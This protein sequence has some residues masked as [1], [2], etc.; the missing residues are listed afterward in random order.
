MGVNF[1]K[2]KPIPMSNPRL[3]AKTILIALVTAIAV[4]A[5]AGFVAAKFKLPV[6]VMV[7]L[8]SSITAFAFFKYFTKKEEQK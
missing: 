4:G 1:L 3:N 7:G 8:T 6:P 5:L 2:T